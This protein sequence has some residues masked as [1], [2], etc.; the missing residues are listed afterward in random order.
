MQTFQNNCSMKFCRILANNNDDGEDG[1]GH[2][3]FQSHKRN[4]ETKVQAQ[5]PASFC[6]TE[7]LNAD[8]RRRLRC[9]PYAPWKSE[10]A[11]SPDHFF[12]S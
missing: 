2:C 11:S 9:R 8:L 4:E 3:M 7:N 10:G 12:Q 5:G 1:E 6:F